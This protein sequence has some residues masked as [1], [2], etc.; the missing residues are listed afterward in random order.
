MD[1]QRFERLIGVPL[2]IGL[3]AVVLA[4]ILG[5]R[6]QAIG[7]AFVA[8]GVC[9]LIPTAVL[10]V[11]GLRSRQRFEQRLRR[12]TPIEAEIVGHDVSS[13]GGLSKKSVPRLRFLVENG[14]EHEVPATFASATGAVG[15]SD[16]R[17]DLVDACYDPADPSWAVILERRSRWGWTR[18]LLP[19]S[20][21]LLGSTAGLA[22]II[23]GVEAG[24]IAQGVQLLQGS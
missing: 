3:L 13:V 4:I 2:C 11:R 23:V 19:G 12:A 9:A 16:R 6:D 21:L 7:V 24:L 10:I 17:G 14:I 20:N 1:P 22:I 18:A 15:R 5:S 8:V